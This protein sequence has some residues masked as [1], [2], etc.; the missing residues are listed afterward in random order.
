MSERSLETTE[1][2]PAQ[3]ASSHVRLGQLVDRAK[4]GDQDAYQEI[5]Q[6]FYSAL[7]AM[8]MKCTSDVHAA[9]DLTQE[10]FMHAWKCLGQLRDPGRFAGWLKQVAMSIC[11]N[12]V[13]SRRRF[14]DYDPIILDATYAGDEY[15]LIDPLITEERMALLRDRIKLLLPADQEVVILQ[16]EGHKLQDIANALDIPIGTVKRRLHDARRRLREIIERQST[17]DE[18][19]L[20]AH[21]A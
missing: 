20:L 10:I 7:H 15:P 2:I 17:L 3:Q 21:S 18:R 4:E 6:Q 1:L 8:S 5:Y 12:A 19:E 9:E 11:R 13:R 16:L 14:L